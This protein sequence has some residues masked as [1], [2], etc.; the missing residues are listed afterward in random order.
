[1]DVHK[2]TI[3]IAVNGKRGLQEQWQLANEPR[4]VKKLGLTADLR[5]LNPRV[6]LP[7]RVK[8][9]ARVVMG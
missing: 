8:K 4:A 9:H 2:G 1:M 3:N 7:A 5:V 6:M